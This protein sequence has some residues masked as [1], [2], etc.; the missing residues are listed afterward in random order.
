M[1]TAA[2]ANGDS[3]TEPVAHGKLHHVRSTIGGNTLDDKLIDDVVTN[4][5]FTRGMF[6]LYFNFD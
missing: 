1:A 6:K 2:R 4:N 3:N 5:R